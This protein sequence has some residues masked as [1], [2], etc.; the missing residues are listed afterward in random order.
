MS[1]I[2]TLCVYCASAQNVDQAYLD[3]ARQTGVYCAENGIGIVYGGGH[4]G[5]MGLVAD[6]SLAL[7]GKVTGVIPEF[8]VDREVGH[9]GLT[10]RITTRSMQERQARM[11]ELSDA[12]L[13]LPGGLGTLAEFFEILTW[14][15]LNLHDKPIYIWNINDYWTPLLKMI[16][17]SYGQGFLRQKPTQLVKVISSL[18]EI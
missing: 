18:D 16:D 1:T 6:S 15:Y 4:V 14:K 2:K 7:G 11:A 10:K 17:Q 9:T 5:L 8:L 12:F 13:I 3:V